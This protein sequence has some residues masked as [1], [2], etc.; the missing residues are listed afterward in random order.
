M[1]SL[2][3]PKPAVLAGL[4]DP[5]RQILNDCKEAVALLRIHPQDGA[6]DA[7][8]LVPTGSAVG[9]GAGAQGDLPQFEVLLELRPFLVGGFSVF[10]GRPGRSALIQEVAVGADQVVL[11]D[12]DVGLG[13]VLMLRCPSSFAAMWIGSPLPTASVA[14][15]RRKSCGV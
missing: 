7:G 5:V 12:R 15:I 10:R 6:A 9:P 8:V 1:Q 2:D 14:N 4:D 11:E 3:F 13:G